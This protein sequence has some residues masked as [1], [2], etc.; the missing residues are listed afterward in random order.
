MTE[1]AFAEFFT[2]EAKRLGKTLDYDAIYQAAENFR[3]RQRRD[4]ARGKHLLAWGV[5][6]IIT[7]GAWTFTQGFDWI[8]LALWLLCFGLLWAGFNF[9]EGRSRFDWRC[10]RFSVPPFEERQAVLEILKKLQEPNYRLLEISKTKTVIDHTPVSQKPVHVE[11]LFAAL[12]QDKAILPDLFHQ[13]AA[14]NRFIIVSPAV[15]GSWYD[16]MLW[17]APVVSALPEMF[18]LLERVYK[19]DTVRRLKVRLAME[20]I[21]DTLRKCRDA[22]LPFPARDALFADFAELLDET[23]DKVG[24]QIAFSKEQLARLRSPALTGK[25]ESN[26]S[27]FSLMVGNLD[28]VCE[29]FEELAHKR[30]GPLPRFIN[31]PGSVKNGQN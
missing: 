2:A 10:A 9:L 28:V 6:T 4:H 15:T 30:F 26:A 5:L 17:N 8:G 14:Q 23:A 7:A 27:F 31:V 21:V 13:P 20:L 16:Y 25:G 22:H 29:P 24:A 1:T 19:R 12:K 3:A 18:F 11:I